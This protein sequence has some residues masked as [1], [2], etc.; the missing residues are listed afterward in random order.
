[1]KSSL[2]KKDFSK[3]RS[4][5]QCKDTTA[6]YFEICIQNLT[7][8]KKYIGSKLV[9]LMQYNLH[10]ARLIFLAIEKGL[11]L[12]KSYVRLKPYFLCVGFNYLIFIF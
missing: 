5:S 4:N 10:R 11:L 9:P 3:R 1:M 8:T 12:Q 2:K 6:G 7:E